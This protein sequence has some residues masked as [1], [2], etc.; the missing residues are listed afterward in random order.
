MQ[1]FMCLHLLVAL[2]T[3]AHKLLESTCDQHAAASVKQY[4]HIKI[5][6]QAGL[7]LR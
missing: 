3:S 1:S 5:D 6:I 4:Y 2:K 7:P